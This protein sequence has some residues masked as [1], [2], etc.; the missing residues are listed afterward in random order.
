MRC[1]WLQSVCPPW[2]PVV[3][4]RKTRT[5][6]ATCIAGWIFVGEVSTSGLRSKTAAFATLLSS[7]IQIVFV[8]P[9][10]TFRKDRWLM[11]RAYSQSYTV[12]IMLSNQQAGW[13]LYI[14][15]SLS[16]KGIDLDADDVQP[17]RLLFRW[18]DR[19]LRGRILLLCTRGPSILPP[20]F[21]KDADFVRLPRTKAG[22]VPSWT[23]CSSGASRAA[24]LRGPRRR[25]SWRES[26][27]Q[28][29]IGWLESEA[30]SD[31]RMPVLVSRFIHHVDLV[32]C[33]YIVDILYI[34]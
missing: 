19:H 24:S 28:S 25:C 12:P 8:S 27:K 7:L 15:P 14:G 10:A 17:I 13:G 2:F 1:R 4:R 21:L 30:R 16:S 31:W 29:R 23:S 26:N 34:F 6:I 5:I 20:S 22:P 33:G 11:N 32:L 3:R 9:C 18:S